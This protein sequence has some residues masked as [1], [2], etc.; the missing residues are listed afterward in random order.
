MVLFRKTDP[1]PADLC[2]VCKQRQHFFF[3]FKDAGADT[4]GAVRLFKNCLR[5]FPVPDLMEGIFN[6][7]GWSFHIKPGKQVLKLQFLKPRICFLCIDIFQLC[8]CKFI[9]ELC[10]DIDRGKLFTHNC[11]IPVLFH[12]I[13]SSWWFE[14]ISMRMRIFNGMIF[15]NDLCSRLFSDS[16]YARDIIGGI[17][18]QR[19]Q[20]NKLRRRHLIA[21]LDIR[22][23][24]I[25][26]FRPSLP[27]L[28]DPDLNMVCGKL[29]KIPVSGNDGYFH[30]FFF[31]AGGKRPDQ[32]VRFQACTLDGLDAHG[33]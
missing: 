33:L 24:I 20:V 30:P 6:L 17:A 8:L 14:L 29:K 32:I 11:Q 10:V 13:G 4:C 23:I 5:F 1:D 19:L 26:H 21:F 22:R 15:H 27:G 31:T 28:G 3:I 7:V 12:R 9:G 2:L 25:F 16:R 18:H